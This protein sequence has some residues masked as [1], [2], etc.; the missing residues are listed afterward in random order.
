MN[1]LPRPEKVAWAIRFKFSVF[2]TNPVKSQKPDYPLLTGGR[3]QWK[4]PL[5]CL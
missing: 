4:N 5:I 2:M 1:P 3:W